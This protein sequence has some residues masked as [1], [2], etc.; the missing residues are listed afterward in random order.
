MDA[1][2]REVRRW[3]VAFGVA[4]AVLVVVAYNGAPPPAATM[5]GRRGV[6][7]SAW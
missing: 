6:A 3:R 7:R 4:A 2:E 1:L 5:I